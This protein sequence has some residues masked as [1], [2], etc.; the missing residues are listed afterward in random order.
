MQNTLLHLW[1]N[2]LAKVEQKYINK[3]L[4]KSMFCPNHQN[5]NKEVQ[6]FC[7]LMSLDIRLW[8]ALHSGPCQ[9]YCMWWK[10]C[11]FEKVLAVH[12]HTGTSDRQ[13][14]TFHA[15]CKN[16]PRALQCMNVFFFVFFV[17][18]NFNKFWNW[19]IQETV[20]C[21]SNFSHFLLSYPDWNNK[22]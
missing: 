13:I 20:V 10:V 19:K 17:V 9:T 18:A 15:Q 3:L 8:Q 2:N 4:S 1:W 7:H 14:F 5:L 11:M 12:T 21:Y 16:A 22:V 6:L